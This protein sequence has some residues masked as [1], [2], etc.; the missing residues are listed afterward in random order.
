MPIFYSFDCLLILFGLFRTRGAARLLANANAF[1]EDNPPKATMAKPRHRAGY[2][3]TAWSEFGRDGWRAKAAES[4]LAELPSEASLIWSD[5]S[6]TDGVL[7]GGGGATPP[8]EPRHP[9]G[10]C[11]GR[12][13]L[14]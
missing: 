10:A 4:R 14:L 11:R 2:R 6:A 13:P 3:L 9:R 1:S 12:R 7:D 5:S 8:P